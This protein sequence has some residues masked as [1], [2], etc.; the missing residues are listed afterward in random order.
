MMNLFQLTS[1]IAAIICGVLILILWLVAANDKGEDDGNL[2]KCRGCIF[3]YHDSLGSSD[4]DTW[5]KNNRDAYPLLIA[6]GVI[7]GVFWMATGALGFFVNNSMFAKLYVGA[8]VGTYLIFVVLFPIIV[9]RAFPTLNTCANY[10]SKSSDWYVK[11]YLDSYEEFWGSS[12]VCFILGAYQIICA[13]YLHS[14][15]GE[16]KPAS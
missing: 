6:F 5:K 10:C 7:C 2:H 14:T 16:S 11:H 1:A 8:G 12:L 9:E 4:L 15:I 3:Y 13:I